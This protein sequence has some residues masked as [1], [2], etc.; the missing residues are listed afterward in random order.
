M[1]EKANVDAS[2]EER[3]KKMFEEK[4]RGGSPASVN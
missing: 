2:V 3:V 1:K 4:K